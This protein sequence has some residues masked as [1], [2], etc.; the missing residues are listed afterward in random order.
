MTHRSPYLVAA[1]LNQT[2]IGLACLIPTG[3]VVEELLYLW[4]IVPQRVHLF[5]WP[6][7]DPITT[8]TL[9]FAFLLHA[10]G[11]LH[12]RLLA[13]IVAIIFACLA[14]AAWIWGL[15]FLIKLVSDARNGDP[16]SGMGVPGLSVMLFLAAIPVFSQCL[17]AYMTLQPRTERPVKSKSL[18]SALLRGTLT[19]L[20]FLLPPVVDVSLW[21][22]LEHGRAENREKPSREAQ[23]RMAERLARPQACLQRW[24][25]AF[26]RHDQV[27]LI[28]IEAE[29]EQLLC[30]DSGAV[31][32]VVRFRAKSGP[33]PQQVA[34]LRL[35]ARPTF[36]TRSSPSPAIEIEHQKC[37]VQASRML[38][39]TPDD[40]CRAA[41]AVIWNQW[42]QDVR[43]GSG[44]IEEVKNNLMRFKNP[45]PIVMELERLATG[46]ELSDN[47]RQQAIQCLRE[48]GSRDPKAKEALVRLGNRNEPHMD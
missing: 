40:L 37:A 16:Y 14:C 30:Q 34:L 15:S 26:N 8:V 7:R 44:S 4:E 35:L 19:C 27:A 32:V 20:L 29:F 31:V 10:Y 47:R 5:S 25:S 46:A 24:V 45:D 39:G 2:L 33:L 12:Q 18:W 21:R 41:L 42:N 36:A 17:V 6:F 1:A 13:R 43:G 11:V 3:A 48:L 9:S 22:A 28:A 23:Q 38:A